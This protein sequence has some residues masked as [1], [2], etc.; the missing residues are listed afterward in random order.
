M[1][2]NAVRG[3]RYPLDM[4]TTAGRS[5]GSPAV[6]VIGAGV[7]GAFC[8]YFLAQLGATVY[9]VERGAVGGE[10]SGHNAGGINPLHGP[11]F[12]SPLLDLALA[13]M[14]LHTEMWAATRDLPG[15][16]PSGRA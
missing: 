3:R 10:A 6:V 2:Q 15:A 8:S 14:R 1:Q 7:T 16:A 13:S 4:P 5:R 9:L 11:G 12:P